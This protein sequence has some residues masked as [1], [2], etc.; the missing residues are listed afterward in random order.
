MFVSMHKVNAINRWETEGFKY[1]WIYW[2]GLLVGGLLASITFWFTNRY[3]IASSCVHSLLFMLC[4]SV[5]NAHTHTLTTTHAH[6]HVHHHTCTGESSTMMWLWVLGFVDGEQL[7]VDGEC[8]HEFILR[9]AL[10]VCHLFI[11]VAHH[12]QKNIP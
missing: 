11:A 3:M 1:L 12:H 6:A 10:R 7:E 9:Q 5:A 2:V 8:V 4:G